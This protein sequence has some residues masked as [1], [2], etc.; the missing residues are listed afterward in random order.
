MNGVLWRLRQTALVCGSCT[1]ASV[2]WSYVGP[3][4]DGSYGMVWIRHTRG[5]FF[6]F[7][8]PPCVCD[9]VEAD[10]D[11]GG[12]QIL[13]PMHLSL[14][15]I[16]CSSANGACIDTVLVSPSCFFS[17]PPSLCLLE[18]AHV[19]HTCSLCVWVRLNLRAEQSYAKLLRLLYA[20]CN[21]D[22]Q[23]RTTCRWTAPSMWSRLGWKGNS[24]GAKR[25]GLFFVQFKWRSYLEDEC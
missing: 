18:S 23:D 2:A 17:L 9:L 25:E 15:S 19:L 20:L 5:S 10:S 4:G 6:S 24:R 22:G 21:R 13:S 1:L 12:Q 16:T 11:P 3:K 14:I 7:L 8:D